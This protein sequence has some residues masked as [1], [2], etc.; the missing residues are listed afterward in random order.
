MKTNLVALCACLCIAQTAYAQT[1]ENRIA[2]AKGSVAFEYTTRRNVC[3]N[4]MSINISD[5][6]SIGWTTRSRRS[7]IHIGRSI[8]GNREI[9]EEGPAR[10]TLSQ[11]GGKVTDLRV[12]VG[13]KDA[14]ADTELGAVNAPEAARYLLKIAPGLSGRSADHAVMGAAIADSANL[15]RRML[16]IARDNDASE[17]SRKSSLFW[18]SQ[19]A[20]SGATAG[21]SAVAM[22]EDADSPVRND[23]LF[24]L[25]Q[26]AHG[27][28]VPAL[29]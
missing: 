1:L 5:D 6:T 15:W 10:V 17:A 19:E 22:D 29:I 2:S 23:A 7:G 12:T 25:S 26:R 27:E 3:G 11:S 14:R 20:S 13:G 18:V 8:A 4:G 9:C 21:L 16:E 24:F 28:G